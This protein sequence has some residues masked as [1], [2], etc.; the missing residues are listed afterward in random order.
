MRGWA[1]T[2]ATAAVHVADRPS[3]WLPGGLAWVLTVGWLVLLIGVARTP[4]IAELTFFGAGFYTSGAWPWNLVAVTGGTGL[5][6][7]SA[8]ALVAVA[9]AT[10]LRGTRANAEGAGR[11]ML[12]SVLCALPVLGAVAALAVGFG[13]VAQAEFNS[14][15]D[16]GGPLARIVLRL[17]PLVIVALLAVVAGAAIHAAAARRAVRGRSILGSL[18]DAPVLLARAGTAA[19]AQAVALNAMRLAFAGLA[20]LLMR[21]LW[22]PIENRL[23]LNGIDAAAMLLLVGFVAIWLCLVLAGGALHAW[24]SVSWTGVLGAGAIDRG[25]SQDEMEPSTQP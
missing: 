13:A 7:A 5:A 2:V 24:G 22:A 11:V 8:L 14:P 18:R 20:A 6:L 9:E 19:L 23:A 1:R 21:V 12:L 25:A 16:G 4:T 17:L 3:L 15:Q 10:L